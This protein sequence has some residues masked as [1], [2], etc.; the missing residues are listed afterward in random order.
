[1][2]LPHL[3]PDLSQRRG[4]PGHEAHQQRLHG[5]RRVEPG[6]PALRQ[7]VRLEVQ[8]EAVELEVPRLRDGE[9][10]EL[11]LLAAVAQQAPESGLDGGPVLRADHRG[12]PQAPAVHF[13]HE[14]REQ[15]PR[16]G[17]HGQQVAARIDDV[18]VRAGRAHTPHE[19]GPGEHEVQVRCVGLHGRG[20]RRVLREDGR[21]LHPQ[22][23][24][25]VAA[26]RR[27]RRAAG[28]R[29]QQEVPDQCRQ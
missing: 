27:R 28:R 21:V 10:D 15:A 19:V 8:L 11:L 17:R 13:V 3:H 6:Q 29:E 18:P 1:M 2:Y 23:H 5:Q 16:L 9:G 22:R 12:H 7:R 26:A 4:E 24:G 14:P 20:E 25:A